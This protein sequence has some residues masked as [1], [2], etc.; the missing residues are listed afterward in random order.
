MHDRLL[1]PRPL[2][3]RTS[4]RSGGECSWVRGDCINL[5]ENEQAGQNPDVRVEPEAPTAADMDAR[6]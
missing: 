4:T 3:L 5:E 6:K 2:R 1:V